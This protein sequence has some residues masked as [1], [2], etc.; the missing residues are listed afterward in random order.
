MKN[1]NERPLVRVEWLDAHESTLQHT[2]SDIPH[3]PLRIETVGW[4]LRDDDLGVSLAGER[5][6]GENPVNYRAV[7]F[8]PR[9]MVVRVVPVL[10]TRK[11]KSHENPAPPVPPS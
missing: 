7:S 2:D 9:G 4:L 6:P 10:K 8:I 5:I 11:R 1:L 3:A